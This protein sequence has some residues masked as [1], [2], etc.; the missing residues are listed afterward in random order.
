M[1]KVG[2]KIK[3][4]FMDGEPSYSEKIGIAEHID[5]IGQIHGSWGGCAPIPGVDQFEVV[6][7]SYEKR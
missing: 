3:I 7:K 6:G 2:D 5:N 4:I 1:I